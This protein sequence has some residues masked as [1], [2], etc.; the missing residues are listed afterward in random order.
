[1]PRNPASRRSATASFSGAAAIALRG[2]RPAGDRLPRGLRPGRRRARALRG[3]PRAGRRTRSPTASGSGV[4]PHAPYTCSNR[5]VSRLRRARAA[6][7]YAP[8]RERG[9]GGVPRR[10]RRAVG[11]VRRTARRALRPQRNRGARRKPACSA[12]RFSPRTASTS[13]PTRSRSSPR[14]TSPS[15]TARART[16]CSAAASPRWA[17]CSPPGL[18]V[19][20]AHR[21]PGLDAVV[22]HVRGAPRGGL[23]RT[24]SRAA[25]RSAVGAA[26]AL[27]LA[28]LGGATS[29]RPGRRDRLA[30]A[31]QAGRPRRSSRS[32]DSPFLPVEDPVTAV[33]LGGSPERVTA[34]LVSGEDRYRKGRTE[35][36]ELTDA[37]RNAR[38]RML[39]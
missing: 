17:S 15:R 28:T 37:A 4:S 2:A 9:R 36:R 12:R 7:R 21:Q 8:L 31:G 22:R 19:A 1:M 34:T 16:R 30:R 26:E 32:P 10:R 6:A 24:G 33:V 18:R 38:S 23:R 14:T 5:A 39:R 3:E 29:A 27:E 11:V 25:R 20:I 35:W 13:T